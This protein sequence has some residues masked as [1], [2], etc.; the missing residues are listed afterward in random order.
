MSDAAAQAGA[1][2]IAAAPRVG[3]PSAVAAVGR[4][5]AAGRPVVLE[6]YFFRSGCSPDYYL[7]D[8][9]A[10]FET[11]SSRYHGDNPE[12]HLYP[13]DGLITTGRHFHARGAE[14]RAELERVGLVL[15]RCSRAGERERYFLSETDEE[16]ERFA[17]QDW[18]GWE[19]VASD[20]SAALDRVEPVVIMPK[21]A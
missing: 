1:Q 18:T 3:T 12:F 2:R 16:V 13:S 10:A 17:A 6:A 14:L 20:V 8:D 21:F 7:L 19:I 11:I 4:V 15:L 9:Q 5:F